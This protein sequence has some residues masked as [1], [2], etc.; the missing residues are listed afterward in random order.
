MTIAKPELSE[1]IKNA[2]AQGQDFKDVEKTLMDN[3][4]EQETIHEARLS[5]GTPSAPSSLKRLAPQNKFPKQR[6][7]FIGV[8]ILLLAFGG[9]FA[10]RFFVKE[11]T[12][13][14]QQ[15]IPRE[16]LV[17]QLQNPPQ[18]VEG[19]ALTEEIAN[20]IFLEQTK[21]LYDA[22]GLPENINFNES[23]KEKEVYET[24]QQ[25]TNEIVPLFLTA[26]SQEFEKL[27]DPDYV[28]LK[29]FLALF[30]F[31]YSEIEAIQKRY[32]RDLQTYK[33][34]TNTDKEKFRKSVKKL[35]LKEALA[36]ANEFRTKEDIQKLYDSGDALIKLPEPGM[37]DIAFTF[38]KGEIIFPEPKLRY[39]IMVINEGRIAV[40]LGA[41]VT[42]ISF[43]LVKDEAGWKF[44]IIEWYRPNQERSAFFNLKEKE[45]AENWEN[46][47][48]MAG[49][50]TQPAWNDVYVKSRLV[51]VKDRMEIYR[52]NWLKSLQVV[53]EGCKTKGSLFATDSYLR[54]LVNFV[55][56][57]GEGNSLV[58][59]S[60]MVGLLLAA[61]LPES[62]QYFCVDMSYDTKEGII[63]E[64]IPLSGVNC[65]M[66]TG[67]PLNKK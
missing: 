53:S 65:I 45:L 18:R 7:V 59:R 25:K 36:D 64:K 41:W 60:N 38:E 50:G 24:I 32:E 22:M 1:Y 13:D 55:E 6:S 58:C 3:G 29:I 9:V 27:T 44:D 43:D 46:I 33:S 61:R 17:Y 57:K 40:G 51:S 12:R 62:K 26:E 48:I 67:L 15:G 39:P 54:G 31:D 34:T 47:L 4:W 42:G 11:D 16:Q 35:S 49:I 5:L 56:E 19:S 20:K 52:S 8:I 2:I 14:L 10:Y 28:Q 66:Q 21:L 63:I 37:I 30:V 23:S